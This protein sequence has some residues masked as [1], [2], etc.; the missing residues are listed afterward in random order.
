MRILAINCGSSSIKCAVFSGEPLERSF[1]LNIENVGTP[2]MPDISAAVDALLA[3][4]RTRW[5][6]LGE[7]DAVVH[8]IVHG[9]ERFTTPA[10]IDDSTSVGACRARSTRPATQPARARRGAQNAR[11]VRAS[12]ARRGVRYRISHHAAGTRARVRVARR[13]PLP[14]GNSPLW[15]PWNQ[16]RT[17]REPGGDRHGSQTAGAARSSPVTWETAPASPPSNTAAASKP[18]WA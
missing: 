5:T 2:E 18:A 13:H 15:L 8:R 14:S 16:S 17:R 6:E 4:L 12:T 11:I 9:G 7:L 1:E 10:L 3:Q